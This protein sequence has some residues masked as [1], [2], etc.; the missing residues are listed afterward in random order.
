MRF[1]ARCNRR[2]LTALAAAT[3][4]LAVG[5]CASD[6]TEGYS[7]QRGLYRQ[8]VKTVAIPLWHRGASV[9]RRGLEIRLAEALAKRIELDTP[10]KVTDKSKADTLLEGTI[11]SVRQRALSFNP[12][13]GTPRDLQVLITV[14][15]TWTDLRTGQILAQ[16]TGFRT[17]GVYY[18]EPP[19]EEEFAAASGDAV[20][21]LA[22]RVVESMERPW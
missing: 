3:V 22:Q 7:L 18:P 5:G 10:Y 13:Q 9:Y 21:L 6:P 16:K 8:D 4:W 14:D 1:P 12:R 17:T 20:N 19:L 11:V 2:T 15:F